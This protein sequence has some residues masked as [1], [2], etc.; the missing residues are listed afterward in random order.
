MSLISTRRV[1]SCAGAKKI[2]VTERKQGWPEKWMTHVK[3]AVTE[4]EF[5][6]IFYNIL[7][8]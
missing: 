3:E 2:C 8:F 1:E 7:K 5:S 4:F 6:S